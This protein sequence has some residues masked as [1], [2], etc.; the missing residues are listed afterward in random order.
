MRKT[1]IFLNFQAN[2]VFYKNGHNWSS[3]DQLNLKIW[4][5]DKYCM[6]N[7]MTSCISFLHSN[8]ARYGRMKKIQNEWKT[9][10]QLRKNWVKN[11]VTNVWKTCEKRAKNVWKNAWKNEWKTEIVT[12]FFSLSYLVFRTFFTQFFFTITR[13]LQAKMPKLDLFRQI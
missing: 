3:F 13:F 2:L 4:V 5:M 9:S 12:S 7:I 10:E 11:W 6:Q 1:V 8:I